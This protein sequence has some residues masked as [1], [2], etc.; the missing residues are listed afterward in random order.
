MR[1][2]F[3]FNWKFTVLNKDFV[4]LRKAKSMNL[5]NSLKLFELTQEFIKDK[6]KAKL[7]V[8]KNRRDD[9]YKT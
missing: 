8:R 6:K 9:R 3:W 4:N 1:L 5:Q 7:F 2:V